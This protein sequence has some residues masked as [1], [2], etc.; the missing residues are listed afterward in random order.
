VS[1]ALDFSTSRHIEAHDARADGFKR[2][3]IVSR[4][5]VLIKRAVAGVAMS[6]RLTPGDFRGLVLRL[7]RAADNQFH[8]E[9]SL[10]HR[11]P[12]L[13]VLLAEATDQR[14]IE[15]EWRAWARLTGLPAFV[16]RG[17]GDEETADIATGK[18][19][20]RAACPRRHGKATTR[21]RPRFL[22]RRK[23]GRSDPAAA[24]VADFRVLFYGAKDGR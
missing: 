18:L 8:Y 4:E 6:I 16:E 10:A 15:R 11:D 24:A 3:V 21:R 22:V 14:Q 2:L 12:D 13:S 19:G 1:A 17:P 20:A 23:I 9:L 7:A 5:G